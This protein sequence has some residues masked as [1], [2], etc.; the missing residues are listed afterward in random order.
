MASNGVD[1]VGPLGARER[2]RNAQSHKAILDATNQLLAEVGYGQLTIEGVAARA[3]VGK[4]TVYRWWPSKGALAI[5]AMPSSSEWS[6]TSRRSVTL[7]SVAARTQTTTTARASASHHLP[8][9]LIRRGSGGGSPDGRRRGC[10]RMTGLAASSAD[11]AVMPHPTQPR[12]WPAWGGQRA[13]GC[14]ADPTQPRWWPA[15]G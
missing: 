7:R 6:T 1:A 5:E 8:D 15:W 2:R 14:H 10:A 13:S 3:G 12:W 4:A 11:S 9:V